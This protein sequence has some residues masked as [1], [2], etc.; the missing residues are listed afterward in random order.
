[1]I[2]S[3]ALEVPTAA[4]FEK[5]DRIYQPGPKYFKQELLYNGRAG[6]TIKLSYREY[7]YDIARAAFTQDLIYDLT[8]SKIIGFRDMQIEILNATNTDINF[9]IR[10]LLH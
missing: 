3:Y 8:E 1:M 7:R 6:N 9:I 4:I 10:S 5:V 2:S